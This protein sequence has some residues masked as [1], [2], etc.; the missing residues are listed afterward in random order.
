[1]IRVN[2]IYYL[3][4]EYWGRKHPVKSVRPTIV[5][6]L[7]HDKKWWTNFTMEFMKKTNAIM[8]LRKSVLPKKVQA[9]K[10]NSAMSKLR[11]LILLKKVHDWKKKKQA[12]IVQEVSPIQTT[13]EPNQ[14][15]I[16]LLPAAPKPELK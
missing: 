8:T 9:M 16:N 2:G 10:K 15:S 12:T 3:G 11:K 4:D 13:S 14:E 1:M 7:G 6:K 5:K